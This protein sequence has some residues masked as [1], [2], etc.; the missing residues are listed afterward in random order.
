MGR[1]RTR[2][3]AGPC[4]IEEPCT[5]CTSIAVSKSAYWANRDQGL[6]RAKAY[7]RDN[8]DNI[9]ERN[10]RYYAET[11]HIVSAARK[12]TRAS[13]TSE[14][15]ATRLRARKEAYVAN[16]EP[17]KEGQRR[18]HRL[19]TTG[20]TQEHFEECVR[21][22]GGKCAIDGCENVLASTKGGGHADHNHQT[23]QTRAVLCQRC[24]LA[25]GNLEHPLTSAWQAYLRTWA[26][27]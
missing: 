27:K 13:E 24:N 23:G 7:R 21:L 6:A 3:C 20:F 17:I 11:K 19:K 9:K 26:S 15:R 25:I 8:L 5:V 1:K 12:Q 14:E 4:T 10:Q 2:P 22:Q 18:H 16:P